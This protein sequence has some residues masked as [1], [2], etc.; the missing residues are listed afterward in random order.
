M[1][2]KRAGTP[3]TE[4]QP[5]LWNRRD[6][7]AAGA[8]TAIAAWAGFGTA[9]GAAPAP[10]QTAPFHMIVADRGFAESRAFADKAARAG[11]RI[12]W[13]DGDD[14][15]ALWYG[16]LDPLWRREQA[17]IAGL[18]AYGA[19]FCLERLAMD[20][21]MRVVFKCEQPPSLHRWVI[22]PK[23]ARRIEGDIL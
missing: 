9:Q 11:Q 13:I 12:G 15:S 1:N 4:L 22:A 19:L 16:E 21:G 18:T 10:M 7:I 5:G 14:I 6:V 2:D 3:T 8:G 17:A 23:S 20:R